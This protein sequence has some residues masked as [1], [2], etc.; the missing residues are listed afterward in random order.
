M[1][2]NKTPPSG[3][4]TFCWMELMTPDPDKA[5]NFY[6]KLFGWTPMDMP[7]EGFN[8]TIF[9]RGESGVGGMMKTPPEAAG[10]PPAWTAYVHVEDV[11]SS[12]RKAIDLGAKS[13]MPPT[14][15]PNIGRFAIITDPTG[16]TI[17]L[18]QPL[19]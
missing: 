11:E 12:H 18:F 9:N 5:R 6:T 2:E 10:A 13:C 7:M 1:P 14:P 19:S 4:G 16:A 3:P 17:A 8:Y 15:I